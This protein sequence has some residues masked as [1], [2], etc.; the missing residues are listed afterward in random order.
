MP[1]V[2]VSSYSYS[3][4]YSGNGPPVAARLYA[5]ASFVTDGGDYV[6]FS[7]L[8]SPNFYKEAAV[9]VADGIITIGAFSNALDNDIDSTTRDSIQNG[10]TYTLVLVDAQ[11]RPVGE[12]EGIVFDNCSQLKIPTTT[13]TTWQAIVA[14]SLAPLYPHNFRE[15]YDSAQ[16]DIMLGNLSLAPDASDIVKGRAKLSRAPVLSTNPIAIGDNDERVN[17]NLLRY[18]TLGAAITAIG[19]TPT[20]L[21]IS[22]SANV[23]T[24]CTIPATLYLKFRNGARLVKTSSGTITFLGLGVLDADTRVPYFEGFSAGNIVWTGTV[25]PETMSTEMFYSATTSLSVRYAM[26]DAAMSGKYC[27]IKCYPRTLTT[28]V[29][30]TSGHQLFFT[31]GSYANDVST[32]GG[33]GLAAFVMQSNTSARGAGATLYESSV[34]NNGWIFGVVDLNLSY[35][36]IIVENLTFAGGAGANILGSQST[37]ILGNCKNSAI[38][39]CIY[40]STKFYAAHLGGYGASGNK[41]ENSVIENCTF[42]GVGTQVANILNG[43][44]IAIRGNIFDQRSATNSAAYTVIDAEPNQDVD[45]LENIII[46]DNLIYLP[47]DN[48]SRTPFGIIV[49]AG[50]ISSVKNAIVRNNTILGSVI[51]PEPTQA[52]PWV[53]GIIFVGVVEGQIYGNH[54]RSSYAAPIDVQGGRYIDVRDN[55]LVQCADSDHLGKEILMRASAQCNIYDNTII[56]VSGAVVQDNGIYETEINYQA[57]SSGSTFTNLGLGSYGGRWYDFYPGLSVLFNNTEYVIDDYT[58]QAIM[59]STTPI[60][61]VPL[62]TFTS[63]DV[64]TGSG[65]IAMASHP[66]VTGAAVYP[67]TAGVLPV[68]AGLVAGTIVYVISVD[69]NNIKLA[70]TLALALAGTAMTYSGAGSGTSTLTPILTSQFSNNLFWDNLAD[71]G[72]TKEPTGSSQILGDV[73]REIRDSLAISITSNQNNYAPTRSAYRLDF[74]TDA[75]RNLTGLVFTAPPQLN[76]ER[77]EI[78]NAGSFNLVLV[79]NATSTAANRFQNA[80][81]A[82]FTLLP[83]QTVYLQYNSTIARW[84]VTPWDW[85]A[86]L[87]LKANLISPALV[88]PNLGT[89][90]AGVLTACTVATA[91]AADSDTSIASTAFVQ[92]LGQ[93]VTLWTALITQAGTATPTAVVKNNTLGGTIVLARSA[94]GVYTLTLA[95]AFPTAART[96]FQVTWNNPGGG[97]GVMSVNPVWTSANVVTITTWDRDNAAVDLDTSS[98]ISIKITVYPT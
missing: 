87:A 28:N 90:T 30:V 35:E 37:V 42:V 49:Q 25:F 77:H 39:N 84:M 27:T 26:A 54:I 55:S 44:N 51:I 40:L 5:S 20:I 1:K 47:Q 6:A 78:Y 76:G 86:A 50:P 57:T 95:S 69:A 36:N 52:A 94:T 89:P 4:N 18:A 58:S 85:S 15:F 24:A 74:T 63:A 81:G 71:G 38:R 19:S 82:D 88:T 9:T 67:T 8:G 11:G 65:N 62:K 29:T 22:T 91:A 60:G 92:G 21:E 97:S 10:V 33:S 79:N 70:T 75:S 96:F 73:R 93:G 72:I 41:A 12:N 53:S 3:T 23:G 98:P 68:N 48:F 34:D 61:T 59:T 64:T 43:I 17:D 32:H 16:I 45:T 31:P 56:E 14:F 2:E 7:P 13:P 83:G 46:E 66:Y 80:T